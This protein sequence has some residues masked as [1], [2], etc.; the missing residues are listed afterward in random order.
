MKDFLHSKKHKKLCGKHTWHRFHF[1]HRCHFWQ[2]CQ[3]TAKTLPNV[4]NF[5][6]LVAGIFFIFFSMNIKVQFFPKYQFY[7]TKTT[8]KNKNAKI[9]KMHKK[10]EKAKKIGKKRT[11]NSRN[12]KNAQKNQK[13]EWKI[14]KNAK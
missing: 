10:S 3:N 1:W 9:C 2:R 13:N 14:L 8:F 11:K 6:L 12:G 7:R 4:Y 5:F